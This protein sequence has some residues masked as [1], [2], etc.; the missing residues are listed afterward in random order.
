MSEFNPR[1]LEPFWDNW[2]IDSLIGEGSFGSVYKI[3]REEFGLKYYSALKI[4][5]VP[6]T[7]AEE[8]QVFYDGMD[9]KSATAYF[10]GI[11]ED[12]YKEISIMSELKGKST[13]VSYE[14][15]KIIQ[16]HDGVGFYIIIRMEL[17]ESLNDYLLHENF[18]NKAVVSLGIDLCKALILCQKRNLIHRDIKPANIFV[19]S[20]GDFKLGDFGIA[21]QL[22]GAQD[23]LSIKGTYKYMAPEV[24][25]GNIYD[26]RVDIYSLGMV[27]YYF[28]NNKKAPFTNNTTVPTY[29]E[30]QECLRRR[31]SGEKLPKPLLASDKFADVILKACEFDPK[32]RFSTPEEFLK[33]LES[34]DNSE[35]N[36]IDVNIGQVAEK[37]LIIDSHHND[38]ETI[39][40]N[41]AETLKENSQYRD[42][43]EETVIDG[44]HDLE[45]DNTVCLTEDDEST[46]YM[47]NPDKNITSF[48]KDDQ[49]DNKT[50]NV[51]KMKQTKILIISAAAVVLLL[52]GGILISVLTEKKNVNT[53]VIQQL[54]EDSQVNT[55][56]NQSLVSDSDNIND[57]NSI[58]D[59]DNDNSPDTNEASETQADNEV[60]NEST[61]T[62]SETKIET[63]DNQIASIEQ[64]KEEK[65]NQGLS[66]LSSITEIETVTYLDVS[67]NDL[68]SIDELSKSF[69]MDSLFINDNQINDITPLSD[70]V[71]LTSL[72]AS[73]NEITDINA[74]KDHTSLEILMLSDNQINNVDALSG[75]TSLT[76]LYLDGNEQLE[77]IS[78]LS[79][80]EN[81]E[82]LILNGTG[83]KDISALSGLTKLKTIDIYN[84]DI[85]EE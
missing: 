39:I 19:S 74:L 59:V 37:E 7:K 21:R 4:I 66:D 11:V 34:L 57:Y 83:V 65:P 16:K 85:P 82:T 28:L 6:K 3:Y 71:H 72:N 62:E 70:M 33:V 52:V 48:Q 79:K 1:S 5:P 77:D 25:A 9:D 69:W 22:E 10:R 84:T 8:K 15:H 56:N 29:N 46:I 30:Q 38:D 55:D 67:N 18:D 80:L 2:F 27:L 53:G 24:Y 68:K 54:E 32:D 58:N 12:I 44:N 23:G 49:K 78:A 20:D 50:A 81:L 43:T 17:L 51:K 61:I 63:A 26:H 45:E 73:G 60:E 64:R 13:I 14:D 35:L 42:S 76:I 40:S 31:F 41:D 36:S 47:A 75:L